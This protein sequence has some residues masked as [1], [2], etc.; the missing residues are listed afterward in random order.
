[1]DASFFC[2]IFCYLLKP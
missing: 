1:M 2:A